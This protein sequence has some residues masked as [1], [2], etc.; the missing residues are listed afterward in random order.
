MAREKVKI[1]DK[2]SIRKSTVDKKGKVIKTIY[3]FPDENRSVEASSRE[4]AMKILKG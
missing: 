2:M 3:F 4:E 1:K